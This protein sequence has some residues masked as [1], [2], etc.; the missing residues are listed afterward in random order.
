MADSPSQVF[1]PSSYQELFNSWARFPEAVPYAGGTDIIRS[2][3][4]RAP[5]LPRN[6]LCL[7]KIE[8]LRRVTR[9]ERYLE[10]GA[11]VR[12][13]EIIALGKIV[14]DILGKIIEGIAG[15]QIRNIATIGGNL[16][17]PLRK[18]DASAPMAALDAHYELRTASAVRWI[19]ASRF[20]GLPGKPALESQ[21]LMTRIRIPLDQWSY[22]T[23]R[24][25]KSPGSDESGGLI[26]FVLKNQKNILTDLRI[27]YSGNIVLQDRNTETFLIGKQ[28]PINRRDAQT[29]F[30]KWKQYLSA[31]ET[32]VLSQK[33][34]LEKHQLDLLSVQIMA[35][36]ENA[37][38]EIAD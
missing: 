30:E 6:I 13:N 2:Q 27:V 31:M 7:D 36:I 26:V 19:S 1:Y 33:H 35:F 5:S 37:I 22:S 4:K 3:G 9:T 16:C 32:T 17:H 8:E 20:S 18:L 28:L 24:K 10:I 21:E 15:P 23:Y 34:H 14:P 29:F 25:F 12:L 11:M 38:L